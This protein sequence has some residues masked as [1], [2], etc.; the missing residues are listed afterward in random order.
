MN[1]FFAA[2]WGFVASILPLGG[3][4]LPAHYNGYVEGDYVYVAA[5]SGGQI[6]Q[7]MVSRGDRVTEGEVLFEIDDAQAKATLRAAEARLA[8]AKANLANLETGS[9]DAEIEVIRATLEQAQVSLDLAQ[10]SLGRSE[11]LL[12]KELVAP[13]KVDADR[14]AVESAKAQ[15]AQ[16][17]AQLQVAELPAREAQ[18]VAA[19][20]AVAA[21]EAEVQLYQTQLQDRQVTAPANGLVDDVTYDEG[22]VV[23]AGSPVVIILPENALIVRFF[24]PE[25]DRSQISIGEELG[26]TCDG[27][28][29]GLVAK[30]ERLA[31]DP[32]YTPPIIFSREERSRMVFLVEARLESN[33]GLTPGQP[34]TV[35]RPE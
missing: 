5:Q 16:L 26:V 24:V 35:A 1:E 12:E 18:Q 10:L 32:Q 28:E 7:L 4:D 25:G 21:A 17:T 8:Q 2:I 31:T 20:A 15:V 11:R 29:D 33:D 34:V 23:G 6:E 14:A 3:H 22:E 19:E 9:R 30:V 27:C 13:A